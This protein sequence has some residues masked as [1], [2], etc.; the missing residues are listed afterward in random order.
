MR[1]VKRCSCL[2]DYLMPPKSCGL[3]LSFEKQMIGNNK[4]CTF[5]IQYRVAPERFKPTK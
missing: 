1:L 3:N 2:M 4:N 5:K